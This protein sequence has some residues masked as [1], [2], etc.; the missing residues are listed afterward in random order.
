MFRFVFKLL[1]LCVT[2]QAQ[3]N[4]SDVN[5]FLEIAN[6]CS[7]VYYYQC[8]AGYIITDGRNIFNERAG[9]DEGKKPIFCEGGKYQ[10][11]FICCKHPNQT[12]TE[13]ST[14]GTPTTDNAVTV[15]VITTEKPKERK[16][17]RSLAIFNERIFTGEDDLPAVPGEF[18]WLVILYENKSSVWKYRCVGSLIHPRVVLTAHHY[19]FR[20]ASEPFRLKALA[21]GDAERGQITGNAFLERDVIEIVKNPDYYSGGLYNDIAPVILKEP[22]DIYNKQYPINTV[23]LS[24]NMAIENKRCIVAGWGKTE[25]N[26]ESPILRK[27]EVPIVENKKCEEMLRKTRLGDDFNLHESFICAGGEAGRDTCHGDGGSPL[28]CSN[29]NYNTMIQVGVTSW[30]IDCGQK[31]VPAA[32][33][34]VRHS[35]NWL[36]TE[37]N[38]RNISITATV[39]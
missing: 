16:C 17:G 10:G 9:E 1:L 22:F 35:Y 13:N 7:C 18:P 19:V 33:A 21:N 34:D 37:L 27:V 14:T 30:G 36:I 12:I 38:K 24:A 29:D 32:Y 20:Y 25:Q 39:N 28:L 8:E 11:E 5:L 26:T 23:C 3:L 31:D 15:P 4:Y 6:S 2:V